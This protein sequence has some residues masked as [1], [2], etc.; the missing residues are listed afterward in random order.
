MK[1]KEVTMELNFLKD[2][3]VEGADEDET[4]FRIDS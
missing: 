1:G 4:W 3:A 2:S